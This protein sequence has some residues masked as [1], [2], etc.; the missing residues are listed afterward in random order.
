MSFRDLPRDWGTQP[1]TPDIAADV[2]DLFVAERDRYLGCLSLL[3]CDEDGRLLVPMSIDG[4]PQVSSEWDIRPLFQFLRHDIHTGLT[5]IA[6]LARR[7]GTLN[8]PQVRLWARVV[9]QECTAAEVPL[10]AFFLATP[11]R[12]RRVD[13]PLAA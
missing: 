5:V 13:P 3:L 4:L 10:R 11:G 2:V 8:D 7:D 1:I 9:H 12:V 6:T